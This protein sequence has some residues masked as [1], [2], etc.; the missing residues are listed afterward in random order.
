MEA[1]KMIGRNDPCSCGSGKKYKR[2]CDSSGTNLMDIIVNEELD[3]ILTNFFETYPQG[4]DK[5]EMLV[6]MREWISHLSDSWDKEHIEE[7]SSEYYL[8]IK[9]NKS[10]R[11]YVK[12]QQAIVKRAAVLN[13]LKEWD[14]PLLLLGE[15]IH[16]DQHFLHVEELFG[17]KQ[18]KVT[19]NDGM[20]A[21]IGTLL[22]GV[23]LKDPRKGQSA[24]APVSSMLFLAKWSKQT[25]K[26]LIEL[27]NTY[28]EKEAQQFV[29]KKAL[30]IYELFIKRSMATMSELVEEVLSEKQVNALSSVENVF[31]EL[32]QT[33]NA[34]E[35]LHKLAVAYFLN[36][37][38][39][40][41][42]VE[43]FLA[44]LVK[45]GIDIGVMQGTGLDESTLLEKFGASK[46][47]MESYR[48]DLASLYED[49]MRSGDEPAA[50]EI[51]AI[52]TDSRPSEKSLWETSMTTGGVVLPE[53]KPTVAGGRAQLL[54]YE[55]YLAET[56]EERRKL[57][58][59][60]YEIDAMN[61]DAILL[62]AEIEHDGEK[63]NALYEKAI[64]EASRTFEAGENP[65]QNI[66]NRPFM[67]AAFTYG[68]YLF[69]NGQFNDAASL[70]MDLLKMNPVD[71]Q[72][73]RYEAAA[74]LIHAEL[75][76]EAAEI[77]IRYEKGSSNDATYLYLDWKLE[78]E[79]SKGQ[80]LNAEE[81]LVAAQQAN[82]H[83][84]HLQTF[85]VK[86]IPYPKFQD[87]EPGSVEEARYI[88]L[89]IHDRK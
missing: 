54:A 85:R 78:Y 20:P 56:V 12:R 13:V 83:V 61:P 28:S 69:E 10:W 29:E 59:R 73:A 88:W 15:I 24:I 14:E 60:A 75:Y 62:Q 4:K 3:L 80:S 84:M 6:V 77:L 26:S 67:R 68:I 44:A 65:W 70:F 86:P 18:F 46:T 76:E 66:P 38:P 58:K 57:A 32:G 82:G 45:V 35:I 25:K 17:D 11:S 5:E 37:Q 31:R 49:M 74:S 34:R 52:G 41:A 53:R 47:G 55:A 1:E 33:A 72:G 48:E 9:N 22:F 81:M 36:E 39:D 7:A 19:R 8:F 43:D 79:G 27:R 87:I 42:S 89:L 2:C 51:Y 63:A 50:A 21:D 30:F 16:I 64:R 40:V 23:V 71:N